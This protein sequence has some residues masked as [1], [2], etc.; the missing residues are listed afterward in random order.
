MITTRPIPKTFP[1]IKINAGIN[2]SIF[3]YEAFMS[4]FMH[5]P[6]HIEISRF[7]PKEVAKIDEFTVKKLGTIIIQEKKE[8]IID[9]CGTL[10]P[11]KS[12]TAFFMNN[13]KIFL[14]QIQELLSGYKP[15]QDVSCDNMKSAFSPLPHQKLV[16]EY[17]NINTPYRGVLLYHGL[18]SGKTC[19]SI[20]IAENLKAYKNVIVMTPK[21]LQ[22]NYIQELKKC[23]DSLYNVNQTWEWNASPTTKELNER[24]LTMSD[25]V[26][27]KSG[28]G[29]WMN[30]GEKTFD[31][32]S[33]EEQESI[34]EQINT[35]IHKKYK[36]LVYN[37]RGKEITKASKDPSYFSNQLVVIDEAHNFVSMIINKLKQKEPSVSVN[38]YKSIMAATN[39]KVVLLTGTPMINYPHEISVLFNMIRGYIT[40]WSCKLTNVSEE[41]IKQ[42]FP[43]A[44]L[45]IRNRENVT[46]TQ[47]PYG[48]TRSATT[49]VTNTNYDSSTFDDRITSYFEAKGGTQIKTEKFTALPD[50][51]DEFNDLFINGNTLKNKIMLKSRIAGL[52]S[53]FP[54]VEQLMP[55]LS[56]K[57]IHLIPMSPTQFTEYV[58]ARDEE[59]K[60]EK[61]RKMDDDKGSS[62]R[63][64]SRLLCNTTYPKEAWK[65]RP[66]NFNN[67]VLDEENIE[68][69]PELEETVVRSIDTFFHAIDGSDYCANIKEYSPK[70]EKLLETIQSK[71]GLQLVYS[72]FLNI[73]GIKLFSRVLEYKG[74]TA[75]NLKNTSSGWDIDIPDSQLKNPMYIIY[76]GTKNPED[77]KE[78]LRN[79]YNKNW[80]A[81]PVRLREKVNGLNIPLFMITS[82]GA[83]GISLKHVQYVHIMEPYWNPIRI[84]QVIGRARRICS[85]NTLPEKERFVEVNIYLSVFPI[86]DLP[87][88]LKGDTL[89]N[90]KPGSTDEYLFELAN[91]KRD[92]GG[93]ITNCI[94]EASID[95]SLYDVKNCLLKT[96]RT[97]NPE[98]LLYLPDITTDITKDTDLAVN[99]KEKAAV[100]VKSLTKG[101]KKVVEFN[102]NSTEE[103]K[104]LYAIGKFEKDASVG[105]FNGKKIYDVDKKEV[106]IQYFIKLLDVV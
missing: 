100:D 23:G 84:D 18:G 91:R 73:E 93:E 74:Y 8:K 15:Q 27:H 66:M 11:D 98:S 97:D 83:E 92:I 10:I 50:N 1:G 106:T 42:E 30:D 60:S 70:Y 22:M 43:D 81:V 94:K 87:E 63:I 67:E 25:L 46:V 44:D 21:S 95:C 99:I 9:K 82:A 57:K 64:K 69:E 32:Y 29:I 105:F 14:Q 47:S 51:V 19:S 104:P 72:Q 89:R 55:Q 28:R 35:M 13:R 45:V 78:L 88:G 3:D 71:E 53:F 4:S 36:F 20:A 59:R 31:N 103:Y 2:E 41:E 7:T 16:K 26:R 54:D 39:C 5:A 65:R 37:G 90:N 38:L 33:L 17:I 86:I 24:C 80:E 79:I 101:G 102:A 68:E 40:T 96:M 58:A 75:F 6:Q 48:F 76:G 52:S 56:D 77:K 85:H 12:D 62:Y 49:D 61:K 34:Q